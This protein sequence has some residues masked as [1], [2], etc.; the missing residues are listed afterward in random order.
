MKLFNKMVVI[1]ALSGISFLIAQDIA[2]DYRL[3]GTN[4]R[5]TSLYRGATPAALYISDSYGMG[6]TLPALT[7]QAGSA[8]N[9]FVNGPYPKNA[10]NAIGV[11]LNLSMYSD[12]TGH[13]YEGSM[14]PTALFDE[15]NCT[16]AP[17]VLPATDFLGYTSNLDAELDVQ[18]VSI[19]GQPSLSPY[20]G[21]NLG[22]ISL[23]QADIFD[24]FP[25]VP[26]YM[27]YTGSPAASAEDIA[28]PGPAAGYITKN[29]TMPFLPELN[30]G[31]PLNPLDLLSGG[32][33][34]TGYQAPGDLYMEWHAI[35]GGISQS[36]FGDDLL[37]DE[38]GDGTALDRILGIPYVPVSYAN[39]EC[40]GGAFD[41]FDF[42][43]LDPATPILG[44]NATLMSSVSGGGVDLCYGSG[45]LDILAGG[46]CMQAITTDLNA[47]GVGDMQEA[48]AGAVAAGLPDNMAASAAIEGTCNAL[49]I[50]TAEACA[51]V[52]GSVEADA[53]A[54]AVAQ[55]CYEAMGNPGCS[56]DSD[57]GATDSYGDGCAAYMNFPGWCG[58]Y[59][60]DDFD[61]MSMCV[62]CGGGVQ[63]PIAIRIRFL[64]TATTC[65]A[66]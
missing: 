42:R 19:V 5:Y 7:F 6:I 14:Y 43:T 51:T 10:L 55:C 22:S 39:T 31:E 27:D 56:V 13:I 46:V 60:D 16:S 59:D 17:G 2:G 50:F 52:A 57:N 63:E 29:H 24:F 53:N 9:Q 35:D 32:V 30:G 61:S 64:D 23:Q 36:G 44:D 25:A 11:N 8:M 58:G 3:N 26:T 20:A 4:V 12:G 49:G 15:E 66:H 18:T 28:Y 47:N 33:T 38:D 48:C 41:P 1:I 45:G 62:A 40:G 21:G 34:V 65:N 54:G 37:V